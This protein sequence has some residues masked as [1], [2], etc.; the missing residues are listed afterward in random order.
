MSKRATLQKL[1]RDELIVKAE[2][3]QIHSAK[4]LA[5][6]ELIDELLKKSEPSSEGARLARG[7]FGLAR[8]L[9]AR[10]VERGLHLPDAADRLFGSVPPPP[11]RNVPAAIP[12]FT[13]AEIYAA[14]GHTTRAIDTL[15]LVL[16]ADP[17][18]ESA[19]ERLSA[20]ENP[21]YVA[22][23]PKIPVPLGGAALDH[24]HD[25]AEGDNAPSFM[26]DDAPLPTR[27]DV[28][29]C[30]AIPVTP[31]ELYVYWEVR[32]DT[33][34]LLEAHGIKGTLVLQVVSVQPTWDGPK[35]HR[36]D[37]EVHADYGDYTLRNLDPNAIT[38]V[39]IGIRTTSEFHP[40]AAT[41]VTPASAPNHFVPIATSPLHRAA[42]AS[43]PAT[44]FAPA[45]QESLRRA[46]DFQARSTEGKD[47]ST[48][49]AFTGSS[50]H[51]T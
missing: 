4:T 9:L 32:K 30:V 19:R 51:L 3:E 13:L 43:A 24:E 35:V 12:T 7:L 48:V 33:Q 27:Y 49:T 25:E 14:Q 37:I 11:P 44:G 29:E 15:R 46:Q 38:R 28:D 39:A 50:E 17:E 42:S 5:R 26:L 1:S 2:R 34:A 22:P 6:D 23:A 45:E 21:G 47:A 20:L 16:A 36:H 10:V 31:S 8:D 41:A 18:N 40:A